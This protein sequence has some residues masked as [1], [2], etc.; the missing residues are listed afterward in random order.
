MSRVRTRD[1]FDLGV[2]RGVRDLEVD[3]WEGLG[4]SG[5]EDILSVVEY[6][7]GKHEIGRGRRKR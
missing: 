5:E 1:A 2:E 4:L 7:G 3:F 6:V